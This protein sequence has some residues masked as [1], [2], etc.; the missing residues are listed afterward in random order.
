MYIKTVNP[1]AEWVWLWSRLYPDYAERMAE[2]A[3]PNNVAN[4]FEDASY[5]S[6][7]PLKG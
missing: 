1:A 3:H 2:M 4:A 7:V 5:L 6:L